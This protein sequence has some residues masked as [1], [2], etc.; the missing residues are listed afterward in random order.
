MNLSSHLLV[1]EFPQ[2]TVLNLVVGGTIFTEGGHLGGDTV[3]YDNGPNTSR[4]SVHFIVT[5]P[6][7]VVSHYPPM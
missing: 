2:M 7:N 5:V 4:C 6:I 1:P 3:H